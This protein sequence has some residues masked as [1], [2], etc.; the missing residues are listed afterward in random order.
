MA[1]TTALAP[2][3][4]FRAELIKRGGASAAKCYQCATCSAVCELAPAESPFPRRQMLWA[5]WGLFDR[6]AAD[7]SVWLCH[8]CNDCNVRC[9]RDAQPGDVLQVLR[10]L[11]VERLAF[12]T[13]LGKLVGN[14]SKTWPLLIGLPIL[15]WVLLLLAYPGSHIPTPTHAFAVEGQ[16]HWAELVP[17]P[18]IYTVYTLAALFAV[19]TAAIGGLRFWSLLGT[20]AQ[21]SGSFLAQL[22]PVLGEIAAHKRFAKCSGSSQRRL[23]HIFLFWGFVGAAVTSGFA[24]MYL[25]KEH[26]PFSWLPLGAAT[27][28]VPITHWVKWIG[29]LSALALVI[30]GAVLYA[31]RLPSGDRQVG[32]THAFDRFF[33]WTVLGVIVTGVV[34]ETLR[35]VALSQWAV[36]LG[37]AVYVAH[38]GLVFTLFVTFPYSKFAHLLY[39]TLA[40]VHERLARGDGQ[41]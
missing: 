38:L 20:G 14:A 22:L 6:L 32:D 25:Y 1:S 21:R 4:D 18:L 5:Q 13:F 35:F 10:G 8:Q 30:G 17:Y 39:R 31:Y 40:M 12:P 11:V 16:F 15:F 19:V 24:V 7:P 37:S 3:E 41:G 26:V 2:S 9:P 27:Y 33:L 29:N 23:G 36:Y 28:P 34:T